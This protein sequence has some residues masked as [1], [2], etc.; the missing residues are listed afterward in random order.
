[1]NENFKIERLNDLFEI[2]KVNPGQKFLFAIVS[3]KYI[4]QQKFIINKNE[5]DK[6]NIVIY[7]ILFL[8]KGLM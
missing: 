6:D 5:L 1:M 7:V 8:M 2:P 3:T 4:E